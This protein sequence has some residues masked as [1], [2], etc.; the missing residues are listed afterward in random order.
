MFSFKLIF[1]FLYK[2]PVSFT[3]Y[4][5]RVGLIQIQQLQGIENKIY[6]LKE[7]FISK[8]AASFKFI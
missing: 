6:Y 3:K 8:F 7:N 5:E 1:R 2:G 4:G